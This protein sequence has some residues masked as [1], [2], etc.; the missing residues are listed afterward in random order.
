MKVWD[1]FVRVYHWSQVILIGSLWYTAEEGLMEWHF[2]FAYLLMS[3]LCT[4]ILW[5]IIGSDT[6][7]FSHFVTS[8]KKTINYLAD[9]KS[10][11]FSQSV[12]HN[13]AGGYMVLCLICLLALQLTTGLFSIDDI[14]SEGPLASL[15]SY[16]TSRL[17][18]SIHHQV[19]EILLGLIGL[20]IA[21]IVFYRVKGINLIS[22][23]ITGVANLTGKSPRMKNTTIAWAI[24]VVML[25]LFYF[26]WADDI[27]SYL[28]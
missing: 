14:I 4:R 27:I 18:T 23:M 26:L 6:A 5:G 24:F 10:G 13:P 17:L 8:P 1:N 3:L 21:T 9:M 28:F 11:N 25:V 20:H 7:K 12:G 16:E 15:V 22:P 19:F 2:T